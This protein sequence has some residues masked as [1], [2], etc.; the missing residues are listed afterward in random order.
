MP[1]RKTL[2]TAVS[3]VAVAFGAAG[4]FGSDTAVA[5]AAQTH[6]YRFPI[7]GCAASYARVHHDYPA[8][9]IFAARGCHFVA[10]IAGRVD[11]VSRVDRWSPATDLG[12]QRGGR[13]VSIVG[14]DGVRYY[15]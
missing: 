4:T 5:S 9:D 6:T 3:V 12:S 15:G 10:P 11:E 8:T 1:L 7:A 2:I 13:S 14:V